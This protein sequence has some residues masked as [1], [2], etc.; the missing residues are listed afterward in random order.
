MLIFASENTVWWR[1]LC[2]LDT[3]PR[4]SHLKETRNSCEV[5]KQLQQECELRSSLCMCRD[6]CAAAVELEVAANPEPLCTADSGD[7]RSGSTADCCSDCA[8]ILGSHPST[9][10]N[11]E[12]CSGTEARGRQQDPAATETGGSRAGTVAGLGNGLARRE[13]W[14][15]RFKRCSPEEG[16]AAAAGRLFWVP[17]TRVEKSF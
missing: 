11:I 4:C 13:G 14:G 8:P 9:A 2:G 17:A 15:S 7:R 6:G 10:W 5:C 12:P 3:L 16:R 1:T